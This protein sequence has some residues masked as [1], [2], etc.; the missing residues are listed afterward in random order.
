MAEEQR[1]LLIALNGDNGIKIAYTEAAS[2]AQ[3]LDRRAMRNRFRPPRA[4]I[5]RD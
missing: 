4:A 3:A 2:D 1:K 5:P